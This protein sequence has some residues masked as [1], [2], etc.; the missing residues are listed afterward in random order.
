LSAQ[1]GL[2]YNSI[3]ANV[4]EDSVVKI[5]VGFIVVFAGFFVGI[6]AFRGLTGREKWQLTKLLAYSIM[7]AL[8]TTVALTAFV[9][10]F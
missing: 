1:R 3:T 6:Q 8:L 2:I 7:C 4:L 10:V 9:L 5:I